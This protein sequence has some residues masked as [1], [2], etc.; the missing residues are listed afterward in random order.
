MTE[1]R[2]A[3]LAAHLRAGPVPVYLV[4]GEEPLLIEEALGDL[5]TAA[6]AAGYTEREVLHADGNFDWGLLRAAGDTLSLFGERRLIELRLPGGKPGADGSKALQAYATRPPEDT[7]L[8]VVAGKLD[9]GQRKSAWVRALAGAGASLYCWPLRPADLP[10]WLGRRLQAQGLQPNREALAELANRAE[11]NLLAAA[12]EIQKL[13]LIHGP[14]PLT[15]ADVR[16]AVID[17][18]RFDVFDL[19][20]AILAG[21][22]RRTL[23]VLD[24]LREEGED[25]FGILG[26]LARD[27][28]LLSGLQAGHARGG[29]P[30]P[31]FARHRVWKNQQARFWQAGARTP[32]GTWSRLLPRAARVDWII[33]GAAPGR[34]WD[35]LL[36]LAI[37]MASVA[38]G[39]RPPLSPAERTA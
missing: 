19:P 31:V 34:A 9:S 28:R 30:D 21:D 13:L 32:A 29:R 25:T 2:P 26:L 17:S 15:G 4:A 11:G 16:A 18:A 37:H 3:D 38:A 5:R 27:L 14:G 1:L 33:K 23:R 20:T 24:G 36:Q 8:L 6:R 10:R 12:Q 7:L 35:E 22:R 39:E